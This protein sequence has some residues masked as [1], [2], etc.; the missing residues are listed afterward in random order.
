M[1]SSQA[2]RRLGRVGT[3]VAA[4]TTALRSSPDWG[5]AGSSRAPREPP[6]IGRTLLEECP[7]SLVGLLG[8]VEQHRRVAGELLEPGES[9]RVGVESPLQEPNRGGA[10]L[11][12]L[13]RPADALRLELGEGDDRVDETHFEGLVRVVLAAQVPD[14]AGPLLADDPGEDPDAIAAVER[15]D[16]R[17]GLAEDRVLRGDRQV[18]D[19]M[20]DVAATDRI[21]VDEGNDRDRQGTDV[22]LQIENVQ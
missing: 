2:A 20:E 19:D 6:E 11:E 7:A 15:A 16:L 14:L 13:V 22:A 4:F 9:V 1:A 21:A 17:A 8:L 3:E 18:A 10:L 12:D 5:R